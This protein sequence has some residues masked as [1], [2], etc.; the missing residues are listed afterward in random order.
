M[1]WVKT[2][3]IFFVI[4]WFAGIFYLPRLFVNLAMVDD[5]KTYQHLLLMANKL[6]RFMV[7]L[8]VLAIVF[9]LWLIGFNPDY[10]LSQTWMYAKLALVVGLIVYGQVCRYY[11]QQF[12]LGANTKSHVFF[13][14][15]NEAPVF[16]LLFVCALV[17]L[18]PF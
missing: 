1:L 5:E 9:G 2:F 11:L 16:I 14:W 18:K 8:E 4:S 15:F 17:I 10:Y 7:P 12:N 6:K 3:H 13:R